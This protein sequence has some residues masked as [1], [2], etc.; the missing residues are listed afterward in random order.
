L[1]WNA[2]AL[3]VLTTTTWNEVA[4]H[5]GVFIAVRAGSNGAAYSLN[6]GQTWTATT[7][8]GSN[9][10]WQTIAGGTIDNV[11][12]FVALPSGATTGAWSI[13][14]GITWF[15]STIPSAT[16]RT[17]AFGNGR[18]IAAANTS[19]AVIFST[20]GITWN[21]NVLPAS[22]TWQTIAFGDGEFV[23]LNTTTSLLTSPTGATGSWFETTITNGTWGGIAFGEINDDH[24]FVAVGAALN[25]FSAILTPANHELVE[26]PFIVSATPSLNKLR[27]PAK[28]QG[29]IS[30]LINSITGLVYSRPDAFFEHRPFDGGVQLGTGGPQH[31]VQAI[32]QSKKYIR[33]QSGKGIMYTTGALFAPSYDLSLAI[34]DGLD[35]NSII[36]FTTDDTDHGLQPGGIIE[37]VGMNSFEYNGIYTVESIKDTKSFRVR[38]QVPLSTLSAV[39]GD[40]PKLLVKNW[41]GA[42]IRSGAFDEQNGIFWQYDGQKMAVVK[43]SSTLQ[44]AGTVSINPNDNLVIGSN[45][46]FMD[47]LSVGDKVVIKG[48]SHSI[49]SITDQTTMTFSPDYRG[50]R[51]LAGGKMVKTVDLVIPQEEWNL[52]TLDGNGPSGYNLDPSRMQMIGMQ[53]TWYAVGFIE[54]MLRG[55]DGKFVFCHRI[56]NSN[57]NTEAYMRTANLPVR[58]EVENASAKSYLVEDVTDDQDFIKLADTYYFPNSGIVY[59][60]NE[61][62]SY[63]GKT[64]NTLIGCTRASTFSNFAAGQNRIYSAGD[65]AEHSTNEG[66]ILISCTISPA[67]SHWGSAMLTDGLFD[68]DRGYLFNY[69][70]TGVS[71]STTRQT[72]F[73]IRLAPSVSNA[74]IG[75]LGDRDLLNRAQLLLQQISITSNPQLLADSGGIIIEGVIN[76]QNY[77]SNPDNIAWSALTTSGAGGQPSFAQI[78]SGGSVNWG[79]SVTTAPATVQGA[80]TANFNAQP[81]LASSRSFSS[82]INRFYLLDTDG[83]ASGI[84]VGDV[85][86]SRF[87]TNTTI[88]TINS[89][90]NIGGTLYTEYITSAGATANVNGVAT[91]GIRAS[92]TAA[93]YASTNFLFFTLP[94]FISSGAGI[95]TRVDVTST[96]FPAGTSINTVTQRKL[97][98]T[99]FYRVGF[100]Q[101]TNTSVAAAATINFAFGFNYALPGEQI[102]SFIANPGDQSTLDL[103]ELK[104][105]TTTAIGGRGAFPNGPDVLAINVYKVSGPAVSA[106]I[107]LRWSEAQ[108]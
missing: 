55:P 58:Y 43:R 20:N 85:C 22:S 12:Y 70:A 95:G 96:A 4:Y 18:F 19:D 33:Y 40:E 65:A 23:L 41:H 107:I 25:A 17:V 42:T 92:Q 71:V 73:F 103:S 56:R 3:P 108:A 88:V 99:F 39:L 14:R 89:A 44:L 98:T 13:D 21:T 69:A 63:T 60:G 86:T 87:P 100:T 47:Q 90:V 48:M 104:E 105:L 62:I 27:Y 101:S 106:N 97:G 10:Q 64:N 94:T 91:I 9:L 53:Y 52:D 51:P 15:S 84:Q 26:G 32:R 28:S 77:P 57:V 49:T 82:G 81:V 72:A 38:S 61:L 5:N 78:A 29:I 30:T 66:I 79:S 74:L 45:T 8:P 93:S 11:D 67:I 36:T 80:V 83:N 68:E 46:R 59:I 50:V 1:T 75:D 76:P 6:G 35:V 31:G 2:I 24:G 37:V 34:S 16:W 7:L 102:F 54:F